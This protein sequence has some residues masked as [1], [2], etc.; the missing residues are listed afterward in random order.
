MEAALK[1]TPW[2]RD[3]PSTF[4][5]E[6]HTLDPHQKA[7]LL[8]RYRALWGMSWRDRRAWINSDAFFHLPHNLPEAKTVDLVHLL[9]DLAEAEDQMSRGSAEHTCSAFVEL[10]SSSDDRSNYWGG[11]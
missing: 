3:L 5:R 7:A 6:E 1:E 2:S 8:S 9:G 10:L 4:V 11:L